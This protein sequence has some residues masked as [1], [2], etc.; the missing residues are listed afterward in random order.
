MLSGY[1]VMP[2]KF[3]VNQRR[4]IDK[5]MFKW[6]KIRRLLLAKYALCIYNNDKKF[7]VN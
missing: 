2:K 5:N 6:N 7:A 1:I 3:A 4:N